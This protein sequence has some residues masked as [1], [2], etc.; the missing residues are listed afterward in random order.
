MS[1]TAETQGAEA[2][3]PSPDQQLDQQ[4][5]RPGPGKL[6]VAVG[7]VVWLLLLAV[8]AGIVWAKFTP[9]GLEVLAEWF[10]DYF[11]RQQ[12]PRITPEQIEAEQQAAEA[13]R[14]LGVLVIAEPPDKRVTSA[15]FR[16][17]ELT[18]EAAAHLAALC[19]MQS[20]NL[21]DS[22]L[23]DEQLRH[24]AGL[25]ELSSLVLAGTPLT[26]QGLAHLKG[27]PNLESLLIPRTKV[28]NDGLRHLSE[29]TSIA[30]LELSNTAV[31]DKGL[32]HL[33]SLKR[34]QHLL[35]VDNR[36]TDAGLKTLEGLADLRRLTITGNTAVTEDALKSLTRAHPGLMVDR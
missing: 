36:I 10:P 4:P 32:K 15:N 2:P 6:R 9:Q 27:L 7:L 24:V 3:S 16:G 5:A 33:L 30:I 1:E 14:K 23:A 28:T 34:L 29:V 8:L 35:L 20:L 19:R 25:T 18:D 17:A 11:E 22:K 31:D 12:T 13:L 26:D 21:A